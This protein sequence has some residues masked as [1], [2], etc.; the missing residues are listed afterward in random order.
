VLKT[1]TQA[2]WPL[3][4]R[5][6]ELELLGRLRSPS[7][8]MSAIVS[9]PAGVG[10]SRLA[11]A[12]MS[13]AA[14]EGWATLAVRGSAG[15][16]AVPLGPFR[17]V[18]RIPTSFELTDLTDAVA[19]ALVAMRTAKGLLVVADDC[20]DLDES[21]SGLLHQLVAAGLVLAIITTRSGTQPPA[22]VTALWK[23]GLAERIELQSL[24]RRET[25]ELLAASVGGSVEDS[26]ANR[27]WHVT[28]GNPLYIREVVL[29]SAETGAFRQVDGEWRWRGEWATGSRLQEIVEARLGRLD[30]DQL[31]A[32]E[33]L[34]LAGSLPLGLVTGLT[35]VRAV[36]ELEARALVT[37]ERSGG[38]LE[39]AIAHPVHAEVLRSRMP[40]L[41]QRSIRRNLVEALKAAGVHDTTDR[42]RLACWSLESGLDVDVMTLSL[43]TDASM[44]GID[45][46]VSARLKEILPGA[47]VELPAGRP[48]VRQD[49][50]LAVR[51]ARAAYDRSGGLVEGVGLASALAW[52]GAMDSA[53]AVLAQ[54]AD[55]ADAI[56]DR[57][58]VTLALSVVRFWGRHD[59]EGATTTLTEVA[60]AAGQ[61]ADPV[62]LADVYEQLAAIALNTARP[63][64]AL[65]YAE[66]AA[67][68]QGVK[69]SHSVGAPLA[70]A[71]LSYLGR[72]GESIELVDQALP[73]V[74]EPGHPMAV[75]TLL[76]SRGSALARMG[77]L[78]EARQ[79]AE[80]LREVALSGE[81]LDSTAHFGVLLGE[82]LI[83]QGRPA[84]AGRIFRDA[85]GLFAERDI[86]GYRPRALSGLARARAMAGDEEAAALALQEIRRTQPIGRHFD[87]SHYLAEIDLHR[88][89]GRTAAA[90]EA[91][92]RAVDWARAAGMI[93]EEAQALDAWVRVAPTSDLAE[94][95]SG[96][97]GMTDSR[98][99]KVLADQAGALVHADPH[100]LLDVSERFAEMT[101]WW[102]AAEAAGAAGRIF[103]GRHQARAAKAAARAAVSFASRCEDM[104]Q[105]AAA[106]P[107]A[108]PTRLTK[109][110]REI[111]TA[112][113]AGLSSREIAERMYLSARTVEN[114]LYRVYVK[115]GVTD[116]TGL[117]AA[118]STVRSDE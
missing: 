100:S 108:A 66:Q 14:R 104:P 19:S 107:A 43:G 26:S 110:E 4:G 112:A 73:S 30:P 68:A 83:R 56:D 64:D 15:F 9:G 96:L 103:E 87:L 106:D 46:A 105:S 99:V 97:A 53:E 3:V 42:V 111:A 86:Y 77:E 24:S 65:S 117:A 95:L 60:D 113:A 48:A 54:L 13:E 118:L 101:A 63:G 7:S 23:D 5:A 67:V 34:A 102:M 71:A 55:K 62:L 114:H 115:L 78:E 2:D 116:R 1:I 85:S 98:F 45:H 72:C 16:A 44:F 21:S 59:A 70:A 37:T 79:T 10:K 31:S 93:V 27:I 29:S 28:G 109:R 81:F 50:E 52:S 90:V 74:H 39:V 40:T 25:T 88:L 69:L 38:Q 91:A 51:M 41:Q 18:L 84:S 17:T 94:R 20:Q 58:R 6:E 22:T 82:I 36:E 47:T 76:F 49:L 80:W 8:P 33:I 11:R 61:G 12:A 35:T 75:V 57:L 89:G 32:M 92:R